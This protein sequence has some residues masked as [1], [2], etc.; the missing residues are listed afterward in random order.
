M[1][2]VGPGYVRGMGKNT[3]KLVKAARKIASSGKIQT[4]VRIRAWGAF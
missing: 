1:V 2:T 3:H 4:A